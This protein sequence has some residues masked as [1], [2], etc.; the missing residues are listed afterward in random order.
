MKKFAYLKVLIALILASCNGQSVDPEIAIGVVQTMQISQLQ[1]AAAG[2][3]NGQSQADSADQADA[4]NGSVP[5]PTDTPSITLTPTPD[6]PHVSVSQD[7]NCRT[8]PAVYYGH[9]TT[10]NVGQVLEVVGVPVENVEYVIVKYGSDSRTCWLWTRYADKKD[11]SS[12]GLTAYDTPATPTPTF[13]PTPEY[14]WTGVWDFWTGDPL[15]LF[16][17]ISISQSGN[18]ISAALVLPGGTV[19]FSGSLSENHQVATGTWTYSGSPPLPFQWQIKSG[20]LNQFV[21]HD[22][23]GDPQCGARHGASMPSP[24][25]WP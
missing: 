8:G 2:G 20:N 25:G 6:I 21:G 11:F 5:V 19:E 24:C 14:N 23:L 9:K 18:S 1:T 22:D 15:T 4:G 13:T 7:T 10:V 3:D 16:P 17:G 12:Y